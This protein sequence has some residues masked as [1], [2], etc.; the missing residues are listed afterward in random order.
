MMHGQTKIMGF[1]VKVAYW[2][3]G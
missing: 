1:L 3:A 2:T